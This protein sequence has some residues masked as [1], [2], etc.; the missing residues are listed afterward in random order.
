MQANN[1]GWTPLHAA[2]EQGHLGVVKLFMEAPL[3]T[4]ASAESLLPPDLEVEPHVVEFLE[5]LVVLN[6]KDEFL[7]CVLLE[8]DLLPDPRKRGKGKSTSKRR[9]KGKFSWRR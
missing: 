3:R 9:S 1:H 5:A 8:G 6:S 2:L 4:V 7:A